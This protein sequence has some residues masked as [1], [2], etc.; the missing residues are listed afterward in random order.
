MQKESWLYIVIG[1]LIAILIGSA[2]YF[3]IKQNESD[4]EVEEVQRRAKLWSDSLKIKETEL[5]AIYEKHAYEQALKDGEIA[6]L[7]YKLSLALQ[8]DSEV[9]V[10][11]NKTEDSLLAF[12]NPIYKDSG[13][14]VALKD[15]IWF[16]KK[17]SIWKSRQ[18]AEV[19]IEA[20]LSQTIGRDS[21]GNFYGRVTTNSKLLKI[22]SLHTVVDDNY[23]PSG[24]ITDKIQYK[25]SFG[26]AGDIDLR[27][28]AAGLTLNINNY[29]WGAKYIIFSEDIIKKEWYNRLRL[30]F[31]FYIL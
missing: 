30:S 20:S 5:G 4:K 28:F 19:S 2:I 8:T 13:V 27:T 24:S 15:S 29:Q 26:L 9:P 25:S 7:T 22:S 3:F 18:K 21:T 12:H 31:V 23:K 14:V 11:A 1:V 16:V 6:E 10:I 17:D